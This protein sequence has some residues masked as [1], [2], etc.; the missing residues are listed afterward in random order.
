MS[1]KIAF[2]DLMF[3]WPPDG[4]S[5]VDIRELMF[6]L[7]AQYQYDV[8]LFVPHFNKGTRR[9]LI[10][11]VPDIEVEKLPFDFLGFRYDN[12]VKSFTEAVDRYN[13]DFVYIADG[14]SLKMHLANSL[15]RKYRTVLRSYAYELFCPHIYAY[16]EEER[17]NCDNTIYR[18]QKRCVNCFKRRYSFWKTMSKVV[19]YPLLKMGIPENW[20]EFHAGSAGIPSFVKMSIEALK[21]AHH[22]VVY[23]EY[24]KSVVAEFNEKVSIIPT[25]VNCERFCRKCEKITDRKVIL[26]SGRVKSILKGFHTLLEAGRMLRAKRNDFEIWVTGELDTCDDF[27]RSLGW[28]SPEL[29]PLCN[30]QADICVVP[31]LWREAHGIVAIEAMASGKPVI[32]SNTGGLKHSVVDGVTGYLVPEGDAAAMAEKI[33]YLLDNPDVSEKLGRAGQERV[34]ER[35]TWERIIPELYIPIF[36]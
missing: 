22:I 24:I 5:R 4:G 20:H 1:K 7:K 13:P 6:H 23:N 35:Y 17:K 30:Q 36:D 26:F 34:K 27:L 2:I 16:D 11:G 9:G 14:Y 32:A 15:G 25:G 29:L 28:V 10:S 12:F 19:L 21:N 33:Q 31:S 18:N 8:K 3:N